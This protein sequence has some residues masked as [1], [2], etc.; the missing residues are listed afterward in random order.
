MGADR[1]NAKAA[2]RWAVE[3]GQVERLKQAMEA[4]GWYHSLSGQHRDGEAVFGLAAN[5][6]RDILKIDDTGGTVAAAALDRTVSPDAGAI[7]VL[8]TAL[9]WQAWFKG[10]MFGSEEI[11]GPFLREGLTLLDEPSLADEDTRAERAFVLFVSNMVVDDFE[12]QRVHLDESLK[13]YRELGDRFMVG[14]V[15]GYLGGTLLGLNRYDESKRRRLESLKL[16]RELGEAFGIGASLLGLMDVAVAQGQLE[17]AEQ[18]GREGLDVIRA[19][20]SR[21][22]VAMGTGQLGWTLHWRGKFAEARRQLEESSAW[23]DELG[24]GPVRKLQS[25]FFLCWTY[26]GLGRYREAQTQAQ[27]CLVLAREGGPGWALGQS[28]AVSGHLALVAGRA[29]EARSLFSEGAA[30]IQEAFPQEGPAWSGAWLSL[31]ACQKHQV[32]AA[33]EYLDAGLRSIV[34]HRFFLAALRAVPAAALL[35]A[36]EGRA[37]CAVEIYALASRYGV[38]ANSQWF[39]DVVGKEIAAVADTLPPD[40]VAAA[41]ERGRARD[42]WETVEELLE[43]FEDVTG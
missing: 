15:S 23:L 12:E 18:W 11:A 37:E 21:F 4:W 26:L 31:T 41:Q 27:E 35:L 36:C 22:A 25:R 14:T 32:Q 30:I 33:R 24:M 28:L 19:S 29:D 10:I 1:E 9:A 38:V 17:E 42:L 16:R 5:R 13:L 34:E 39:K 20:G 40:I 43:E 2:W 6:L 8:I 7:R 3:G